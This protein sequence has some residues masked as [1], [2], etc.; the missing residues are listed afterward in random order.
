[1]VTLTFA[2]FCFTA[3]AKKPGAPPGGGGGGTSSY[4]IV[5]LAHRPGHAYGINNLG[6]C[7][8]EITDIDGLTKPYFWLVNDA[9]GVGSFP[10]SLQAPAEDPVLTTGSAQDIN[11]DGLI[12]GY[13]GELAEWTL[14]TYWPDAL[15]D[16]VILPVP[17]DSLRSVAYA[18]NSNG[19][20]VGHYLD[21]LGLLHPVA[22]G[23]R[24]DA[25]I[26]GP[27][28]M[29]SGPGSRGIAE[30]VNDWQTVVGWQDVAGHV[31]AW[32]WQLVWDEI[33]LS[34]ESGSSLTPQFPAGVYV[35]SFAHSVN[36]DGDIC[37]MRNPGGR[38]E[39]YFL[40]RQDGVLVEQPLAFLVDNKRTG[41][42]NNYARSLNNASPPQIVGEAS[43]FAKKQPGFTQ[44]FIAVLWQGSTIVD[45]Q[46]G[47]NSPSLTASPL[48]WAI[49]DRGWIAGQ[50]W[51][52]ET[53][54]PAVP[55]VILPNP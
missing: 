36:N 16:P 42:A 33:T 34:L 41:S 1:M 40:N 29:Q 52:G 50:A 8:G 12:V 19:V 53:A 49:N 9:G 21:S 4:K 2:L 39:A 51:T 7:V 13:C 44:G 14:A 22:W 38:A 23:L 35:D 31:E 24:S 3:Q 32:V 17:L 6:D 27:V 43:I 37:G 45:L 20:V 55:S 46:K 18:V 5:E 26:A 15:A 11:D 10:L 25:T 47:A 30:D 28:E 54:I 48:M